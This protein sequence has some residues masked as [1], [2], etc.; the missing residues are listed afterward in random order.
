MLA[1]VIMLAESKVM[2]P[3]ALLESLFCEVTITFP[4]NV[5]EATFVKS[6]APSDS[7][8]PFSVNTP[9]VKVRALTSAPS[10]PTALALS[11]V[12]VRS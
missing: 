6:N 8:S 2:F 3:A 11:P 5:I 4:P 1:P 10:T 7:T 12:K 9:P